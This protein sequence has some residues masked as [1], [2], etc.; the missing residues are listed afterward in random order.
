MLKL[1]SKWYEIGFM[2][3]QDSEI[4]DV[5]VSNTVLPVISGPVTSRRII[6]VKLV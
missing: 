2:G 5:S 1:Q 4:A 3:R 6:Q